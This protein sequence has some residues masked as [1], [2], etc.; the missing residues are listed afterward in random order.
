MTFFEGREYE[1]SWFRNR[2]H[3]KGKM[4]WASGPLLLYEV[5]EEREGW[6]IEGELIVMIII[7][8][9]I[10]RVSGVKEK[11]ME[12][13]SY[14]FVMEQLLMVVGNGLLFYSC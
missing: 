13:E 6:L 2:C 11:D 12:V 7:T 4:T 8:L 9:V 5:C 14:L 3:G 1:G 10:N